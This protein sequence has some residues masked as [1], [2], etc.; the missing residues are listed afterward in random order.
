[1]DTIRSGWMTIFHQELPRS[2][3]TFP[4]VV[5]KVVVETH[6]PRPA[7]ET[8]SRP[9]QQ[10]GLR[11]LLPWRSVL[12]NFFQGRS[13]WRLGRLLLPWKLTYPLK[14]DGWKL[15]DEFPFK[16]DP[17][18]MGMNS[19]PVIFPTGVSVKT[20]GRSG[21][22]PEMNPRIEAGSCKIQEKFFSFSVISWWHCH[23]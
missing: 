15:E 12:L 22:L 19:L 17:F 10:H 23:F 2:Q 1:M 14:N 13:G 11:Q 9:W 4:L 7:V 21:G 5:K 6:W 20:G 8:F 18:L 16:H 3:M